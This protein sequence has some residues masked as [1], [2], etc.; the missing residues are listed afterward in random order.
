M[1]KINTIISAFLLLT[2]HSVMA[3]IGPGGFAP[4]P[5]YYF[6][7]TGTLGGEAIAKVLQTNMFAEI[8]SMDIEP[9][10]IKDACLRFQSYR[11]VHLAQGDT[12]RDLGKFIHKIDRP[13]TF[14][15]DAHRG[16]EDPYG[17]KNTPLLEELEQIKH[18]P[19]KTHTI[20]IDDMHCCGTA[21]FDFITRE[22]IA[23]KVLEIN[24]NY[25][26]SYIP[27]GNEGEYPNNIMVAQVTQ[28]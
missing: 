20:L 25:T 17:A 15:L 19:I 21:L 28:K 12:A 8:Y 22:Q 7:E 2:S 3:N 5:N 14:W 4:F 6:I 23:E 16:T 26:I 18:H 13:A 9:S 1:R 10:F 11:N 27:G 24:P